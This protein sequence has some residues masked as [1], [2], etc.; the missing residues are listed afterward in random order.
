[1]S[2]FLVAPYI[3]W[4]NEPKEYTLS[5]HEVKS[6]FSIKLSDLINPQFKTAIDIKSHSGMTL[7]Q[8]PC[9]NIEGKIIWGATS[10]MLNELKDIVLRIKNVS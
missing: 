3:G 5:L 2:N 7:K 1:M 9:F 4:I 6:V 10:L 8:M